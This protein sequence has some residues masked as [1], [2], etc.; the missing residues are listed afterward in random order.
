MNYDLRIGRQAKKEIKVL[1]KSTI[2]RLGERFQQLSI[3]PFDPRISKA[4]RMFPGRRTSRVGDWRIIYE[5][6]EPEKVIDVVSIRA[7]REAY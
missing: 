7:R 4:V 2:K 5:V 3:N 1:D 6:N